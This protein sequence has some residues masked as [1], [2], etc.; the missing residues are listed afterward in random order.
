MGPFAGLDYVP[1]DHFAGPLAAFF[2][3]VVLGFGLGLAILGLALRA[4]QL[5][6][7]Q[8]HEHEFREERAARPLFEGPGRVV[9]GTVDVD[10]AADP[11]AVAVDIEQLVRNVQGKSTFTQVWTEVARRVRAR[12]FYVRTQDG[13]DV[14]VEPSSDVLVVDDL[15][16]V[17]PRDMPARR[18]REASVKRGEVIHVYGDLHRG[19]HPR[20]GGAATRDGVGF[21]LR[22]PSRGRMLLASSAIEARYSARV[23]ALFFSAALLA[24]LW[25]VATVLT[26]VPYVGA[27]LGRLE[28][29]TV[30]RHGIRDTTSKGHTT[31]H[32]EITARSKSGVV[33]EDE[34]PE[35]TYDAIAGAP[36]SRPVV[37]PVRPGGGGVL[38]ARA[39][40]SSVWLVF[41]TVSFLLGGF[42]V[43]AIVQAKYP[44]YDKKKIVESRGGPWIEPR[45]GG[46]VELI[47]M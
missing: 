26:A 34:V 19:A 23:K 35:A 4:L 10:D 20:P 32:Y 13:V 44:W 46:D 21:T 43:W 15:E 6:A 11:V 36:M 41:G 29:G 28:T 24:P 40:F 17:Y 5:A 12:P 45:P 33:I 47:N 31:H 9:H 39:S 38:G 16:S 2:G 3:V 22:P 30:I 25:A 7:R 18:V 1:P 27:T 42:L 8:R 37:I 14:R